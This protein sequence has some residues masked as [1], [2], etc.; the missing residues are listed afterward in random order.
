MYMGLQVFVV[1][2]LPMESHC[3]LQLKD[4]SAV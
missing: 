4:R 1:D 3:V 2:E